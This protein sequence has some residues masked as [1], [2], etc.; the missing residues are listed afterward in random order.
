MTPRFTPRQIEAFLAVAE[1]QSFRLGA[2]RINVTPSAISNLIGELED[3]LGFALFERTT[4]RV[5]LTAAGRRFLPSA[6]AVQRQIAQAVTAAADIRDGATQVVRIAAPLTLAATLLPYLIATRPK[7]QRIAVRIIDTPVVWLADRV[8]IGEAD[9]AIGPDRECPPHI[10]R[11]PISPTPWQLWMAPD[12][13]LAGRESIPWHMLERLPMVA[14]GRDHEQSIWPHIVASGT[15]PPR[16][17]QIVEHITTTLGLAAAGQVATFS[18]DYVAPLAAAFGLVGRPLVEPDIERSLCLYARAADR[19]SA[20]VQT[21]FDHIKT[22][23]P[24]RLATG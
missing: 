20:A 10:A 22:A 6:T 12:H 11:S 2:S 9:L 8:A 3:S 17:V 18:P 23:T 24:V 16:H 7:P 13:P 21:V 15:T 5:A 1:L 14:A 19:M 4:R